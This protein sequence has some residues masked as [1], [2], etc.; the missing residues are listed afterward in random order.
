MGRPG[1]IDQTRVLSASVVT[2]LSS[3]T[4]NAVQPPTVTTQSR[5]SAAR[6]VTVTETLSHS[7]ASVETIYMCCFLMHQTVHVFLQAACSMVENIL[8]R[9]SLVMA[10]TPVLC[11]SVTEAM[12]LALRYPVMKTAATL[13]NHPD[14]A[15]ENV[16]VC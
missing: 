13:T 9:L 3:V 11:V 2:A 12:S 16:N 15:V 14:N 5:D 6:P 7:L 10:E 8:K 1:M 4:G